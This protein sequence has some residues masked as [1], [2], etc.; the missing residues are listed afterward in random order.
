MKYNNVN[1]IV[2]DTIDLKNLF[3]HTASYFDYDTR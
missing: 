3:K 2:I 1:E